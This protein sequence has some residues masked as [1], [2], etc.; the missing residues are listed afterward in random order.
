MFGGFPIA[1]EGTVTRVVNLYS[2]PLNTP[3][4]PRR[5]NAKVRTASMKPKLKLQHVED[6]LRGWDYTEFRQGTI[7]KVTEG[8][9]PVRAGLP[10][11]VGFHQCARLVNASVIYQRMQAAQLLARTYRR[12]PIRF[13]RRILPNE[14]GGR[15]KFECQLAAFRLKHVANDDLGSFRDEQASLGCALTACSSTDE[16][17]FPFEAVHFEPTSSRPLSMR[18]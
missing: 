18:H 17:D 14:R 4:E 6:A 7:I 13:L 11:E 9:S 16:Y 8:W 5:R 12:F 10:P 1:A 15:A 3:E 2:L